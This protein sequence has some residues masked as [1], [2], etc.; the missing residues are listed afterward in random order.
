MFRHDPAKIRRWATGRGIEVADA[1]EPGPDGEPEPGPD[2]EPEPGPDGE[3]GSGPA[4]QPFFEEYQRPD[5]ARAEL[6]RLGRDARLTRMTEDR[7]NA[8]LARWV[9]RL[10]HEAAEYQALVRTRKAEAG[11][12]A[13]QVA[14]LAREADQ[15][16]Q[17]ARAARASAA[18]QDAEDERAAALARRVVQM[19]EDDK[20]PDPFTAALAALAQNKRRRGEAAADDGPRLAALAEAVQ[21]A[22][23]RRARARQLQIRQ[24]H[25]NRSHGPDSAEA[26]AVRRELAAERLAMVVL[27]TLGSGLSSDDVVSVALTGTLADG[28]AGA[29]RM[30]AGPDWPV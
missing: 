22:A 20:E 24:I 5:R 4:G 18:R 29:P 27:A 16:E 21:G 26:A 17:R 28:P 9:A 10:R 19:L 30:I 8:T 1:P 3:P 25:V 7:D 2:G 15:A 11:A 13:A 12:L 23:E 14:R 6:D